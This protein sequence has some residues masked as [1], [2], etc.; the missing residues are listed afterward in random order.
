MILER[1]GKHLGRSSEF[2]RKDISVWKWARFPA[3]VGRPHRQRLPRGSKHSSSSVARTAE[4]R[5]PPK[6]VSGV[7]IL[8][9]Q[10]HKSKTK[11]PHISIDWFQAKLGL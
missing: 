2:A 4:I 1:S 9:L 5:L 11:A 7:E 10:A 8:G 3:Q 6:I